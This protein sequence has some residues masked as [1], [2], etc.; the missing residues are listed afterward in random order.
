MLLSLA[1]RFRFRFNTFFTNEERLPPPP[2][3]SEIHA[4]GERGNNF[5]ERVASGVSS[6]FIPIKV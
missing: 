5:N 1:F 3:E 6:I 2:I 4:S